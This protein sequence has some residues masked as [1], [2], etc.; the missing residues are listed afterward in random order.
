LGLSQVQQ[1]Y[2]REGADED[3]GYNGTDSLGI[4]EQ[5]ENVEER[6]RRRRD[7]WGTLGQRRSARLIQI[8]EATQKME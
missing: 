7:C 1:Q 4:E 6:P 2:L 5:I 3:G 8:P